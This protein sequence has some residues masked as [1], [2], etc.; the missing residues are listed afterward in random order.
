MSSIFSMMLLLLRKRSLKFGEA[1]VPWIGI[2]RRTNYSLCAT[3]ILL[4][5]CSRV[6]C[7]PEKLCKI[8]LPVRTR[9]VIVCKCLN[10]TLHQNVSN[11]IMSGISMFF[12]DVL[13]KSSANLHLQEHVYST[14]S[15]AVVSGEHAIRNWLEISKT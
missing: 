11:L 14:G 15:K 2:N 13:T 12:Q 8:P 3:D 4:H 5:V 7:M 9:I 6:V 1:D 10:Q